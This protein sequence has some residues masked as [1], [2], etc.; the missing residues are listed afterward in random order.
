MRR[1]GLEPC[2][3]FHFNY[4]LFGPIWLARRVI[5]MA[6]VELRSEG[7]VNTPLLNLL[8][9]GIFAVDLWTAPFIRPPFG[10]SI[11][12]LAQKPGLPGRGV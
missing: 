9:K 3:A 8:L 2:H 11:L 5:R 10:V 1:A 4:L 6:Q 12:V 7:E